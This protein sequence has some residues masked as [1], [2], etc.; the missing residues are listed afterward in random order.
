VVLEFMRSVE[1]RESGAFDLIAED[2]VDRGRV[3]RT[4]AETRSADG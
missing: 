4:Q 1:A 3:G 2:F